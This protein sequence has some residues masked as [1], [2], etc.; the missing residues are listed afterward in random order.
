MVGRYIGVLMVVVVLSSFAHAHT[1]NTLTG[2]FK[3]TIING[4]AFYQ[5]SVS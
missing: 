5:I 3:K 1:Q 2:C 4:C